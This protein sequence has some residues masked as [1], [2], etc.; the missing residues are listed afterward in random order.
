MPGI[1]YKFVKKYDDRF[2][3]ISIRYT[4]K[5]Y[6]ET[7]TSNK[8]SLIVADIDQYEAIAKEHHWDI[9]TSAIE[10]EASFDSFVRVFNSKMQLGEINH[11]LFCEALDEVEDGE[12]INNLKKRYRSKIVKSQ[13]AEKERIRIRAE[14][15]R[16]KR[17][18]ERLILERRIAKQEQMQQGIKN[19][20]SAIARARREELFAIARARRQEILKQREESERQKQEQISNEKKRKDAIKAEMERQEGMKYENFFAHIEKPVFRRAYNSPKGV[21]DFIDVYVGLSQLVADEDIPVYV[22][23]Y[24]KRLNKEI[25]SMIAESPEF[26]KY[27][28]PINFLKIERVTLNKKARTLYYLISLKDT[29][30]TS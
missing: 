3:Y 27:G 6:L 1:V 29:N 21:F 14:Q 12:P 2:I 13:L 28:I 22:G 15:G 5:Y 16:K 24:S 20:E 11:D 10:E 26:A 17:E 19:L 18:E 9:V 30:Q 7:A 4:S 23:Q 8:I 25:I